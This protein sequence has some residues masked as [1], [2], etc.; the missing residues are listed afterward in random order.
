MKFKLDENLDVRLSELLH[1]HGHDAETV[2]SEH[3]C[4]ASDEI[5]FLT[6][7]TEKRALITL[8]LDFSNILRFPPQSMDGIIILR[9]YT[10]TLSMIKTMIKEAV[11]AINDISPAG[12]LLIVEP[13]RI[14][15]YDPN[16][17]S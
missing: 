8:D 15:I 9:P 13:G 5:V 11:N 12:K 16:A 10:H 2:F 4:G 1:E 7:M 3:I 6:C 17:A 14:R